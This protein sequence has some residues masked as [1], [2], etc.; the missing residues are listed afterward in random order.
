M[1]YVLLNWDK[2][3]AYEKQTEWYELLDLLRNDTDFY[4]TPTL[5]LN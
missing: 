5:S 3:K 4:F 2:W 1:K